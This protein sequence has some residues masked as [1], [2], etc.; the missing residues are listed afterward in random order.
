[1]PFGH[2][3]ELLLSGVL[4]AIY[5]NY[6]LQEHC[7]ATHLANLYKMAQEVSKLLGLTQI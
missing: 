3:T 7:R 1:M 5:L 2:I 6:K 4:P